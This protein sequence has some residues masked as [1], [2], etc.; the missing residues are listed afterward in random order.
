[1]EDGVVHPVEDLD[2]EDVLVPVPLLD[3]LWE[4][5]REPDIAGGGRPCNVWRAVVKPSR[6]GYAGVALASKNADLFEKL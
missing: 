3:R 2:R 6:V 1:M 5:A 4:L